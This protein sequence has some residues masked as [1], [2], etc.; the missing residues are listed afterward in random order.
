MSDQIKDALSHHHVRGTLT[1]RT[2][3]MMCALAAAPSPTSPAP[4]AA[5]AGSPPP[6]V[7]L[8]EIA[9]R[10]QATL[11]E[12]QDALKASRSFCVRRV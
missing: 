3:W 4:T 12:V 9:A 10:R 1:K 7:P 5:P 2:L 8:A 6:Q 11:V